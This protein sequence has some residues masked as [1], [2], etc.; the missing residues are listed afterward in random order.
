[1]N[2]ILLVTFLLLSPQAENPAQALVPADFSGTWSTVEPITPEES[3]QVSFQA[4]GSVVLTREFSDSPVQKLI[5]KSSAVHRI[6]D[7][8]IVS[9]SEGNVL[10][11]RLV[12]TGW[13]MRDKK[14]LFGTLYLYSNNTVFNGI[15]ISLNYSKNSP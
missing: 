13:K 6:D 1:M 9:F 10:K 12:L 4:D 11:Y 14:R 8:V 2:A 3:T 7:L 15:P 5:A